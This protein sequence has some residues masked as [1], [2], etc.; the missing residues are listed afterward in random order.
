MATYAV[1]SGGTLS[2]TQ[3]QGEKI[4]EEQRKVDPLVIKGMVG[5]GADSVIQEVDDLEKDKE[6]N[7]ADFQER[8]ANGK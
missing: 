4:A 3:Y 8:Y 1:T 2:V 5:E 6:F 7:P